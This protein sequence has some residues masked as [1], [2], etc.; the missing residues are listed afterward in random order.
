[1][2]SQGDNYDFWYRYYIWEMVVWAKFVMRA[3]D[4]RDT[5]LDSPRDSTSVL[6]QALLRVE[7]M[8]WPEQLIQMYLNHCEQHESVQEYRKAVI[9]VRKATKKVVDR[10]ERE[11]AAWTKQQADQQQPAIV[12]SSAGKRKWDAE[13]TTEEQVAKKP[14]ADEEPPL[15]DGDV[16]FQPKR[17]RE[18]TTI[19]VKHLPVDATELKIRQFFRD[20]SVSVR[21]IVSLLTLR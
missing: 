7:T 3:R 16:N 12:E 18:H 10:R 11:A 17:D 9:E 19:I 4:E 5:Q 14:K 21:I 13:A 8:D 15:V 6:R 1:V 2:K 20:V